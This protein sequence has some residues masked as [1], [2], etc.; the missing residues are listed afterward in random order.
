MYIQVMNIKLIYNEQDGRDQIG[1]EV[2]YKVIL[3][4]GQSRRSM[5]ILGTSEVKII[6]L[7]DDKL[8]GTILFMND[9]DTSV[10]DW[11]LWDFN[12]RIHENIIKNI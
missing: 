9:I 4:E 5:P 2:E 8:K 1:A 3:K 10:C 7:P 12:R 6:E 11:A